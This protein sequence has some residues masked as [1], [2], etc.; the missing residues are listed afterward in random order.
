MP[1]FNEEI[2]GILNTRKKIPLTFWEAFRIIYPNIIL[3]AGTGSRKND[4]TKKAIFKYLCDKQMIYRKKPK[5]EGGRNRGY[6]FNRKEVGYDQG[7]VLVFN[8]L[9]I[10]KEYFKIARIF[11]DA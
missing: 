2:K 6:T 8:S 10:A 1:E 3:N 11:K 5:I 7:Q 9:E 4:E